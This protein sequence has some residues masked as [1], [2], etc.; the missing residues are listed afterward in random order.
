MCGTCTNSNS[1]ANHVP[2]IESLKAGVLEVIEG[3]NAESKKWFGTFLSSTPSREPTKSVW[4]F[5]SIREKKDTN[6]LA[7][8][9]EDLARKLLLTIVC[10]CHEQSVEDSPMFTL[11]TF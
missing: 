3:S 9:A 5:Q 8:C 6:W 1:L 11:T 4:R 2:S 7:G 10:T